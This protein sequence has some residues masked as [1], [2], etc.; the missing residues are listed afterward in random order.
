MSK[1]ENMTHVSLDLETMGQKKDAAIIAIGACFFNPLSGE[2]GEQF[3]TQVNLDI[4]NGVSNGDVTPSTII[5]W[6]KQSDEARQ[7]FFDN[8]K[9][10]D[11]YTA[12]CEFGKFIFQ[13]QDVQVWGNG[14]SFDNTI[15]ES[16]YDRHFKNEAPWEFYRERDVR[17]MV[18]IGEQ[19][20]VYPKRDLPFEGER[21]YALADAIHQAKIIHTVW[22]SI[23]DLHTKNM[24]T[25]QLLKN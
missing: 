11:I 9:A 16:A 13:S 25:L 20:G 7:K 12:L 10:P 5:W 21:H 18:E 14:I 23:K 24:P 19:I 8:E 4:G 15:M 3:Y 1:P 17:T 6:L 2:I 22:R